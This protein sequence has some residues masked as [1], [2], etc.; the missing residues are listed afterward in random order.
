VDK[1]TKECDPRQR[2]T[3]INVCAR[4]TAEK[5]LDQQIDLA[6]LGNAVDVPGYSFYTIGFESQENKSYQKAYRLSRI[7]NASKAPHGKFWV[8]ETEIGPTWDFQPPY[9][10]RTMNYWQAVGH[11]AKALLGWNYRSRMSDTQ[12]S[13]FHMNAWD[14]GITERAEVNGEFSGLLQHHAKF[15]NDAIPEKQAA[16][17]CFEQSL[18]DIASAYGASSIYRKAEIQP[19]SRQVELYH[20]SRPGAFKMLWDM[21]IAADFISEANIDSLHDYKLLL[22]PMQFNMSPELAETL[23]GYVKRGGTIIA[24]APFAFKD[25][26]NIL[27]EEAPGFGLNEV[28]GGYT[29]DM[30]A[31]NAAPDILIGDR[32][33][34]AGNIYQYFE[35]CGGSAAARYA[36]DGIAAVRNKYGQGRTL[37]LGTDVFRRYFEC[38]DATMTAFLRDEIMIAGVKP[39]GEVRVDG[40]LLDAS[41]IEIRKLKS[42]ES[43]LV[44][45]INHGQDAF[46]GNISINGTTG[47]ME[48]LK[49]GKM[50]DVLYD[51][52]LPA[53]G[54]LA[55]K[56]PQ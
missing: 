32:N 16:V 8:L 53:N 19:E 50:F 11:G 5:V 25:N 29:S 10:V 28:F 6:G 37:L 56:C 31:G 42:G 52:T 39:A 55:L 44:I 43:R 48:C 7:R 30:L 36:D 4:H 45:I 33:S 3:T 26:F 9:D 18:R 27:Q 41:E 24:E 46:T 20:R 2:P 40:E 51:I 1:L 23:R 13:S 34:P 12:V 47:N 15:I 21:N 49:T 22:I 54:V 14:G 38:Q 17:L 35:L